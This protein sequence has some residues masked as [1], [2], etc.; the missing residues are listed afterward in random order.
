MLHTSPIFK[1]LTLPIQMGHRNNTSPFFNPNPCYHHGFLVNNGW[2]IKYK[3][4][5]SSIKVWHTTISHLHELHGRTQHKFIP[6]QANVLRKTA[7]QIMAKGR[8]NED[9][10]KKRRQ[11]HELCVSKSKYMTKKESD[12]LCYSIS[13]VLMKDFSNDHSSL[14]WMPMDVLDVMECE[15]FFRS[16]ITERVHRQK[17]WITQL[18]RNEIS[19]TAWVNLKMCWQDYKSVWTTLVLILDITL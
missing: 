7:T 9:V 6:G 16:C 18:L 5:N 19:L 4:V 10:Q 8:H 15:F 12:L 1:S 17:Q 14:L 11:L 3:R 2:K 13:T